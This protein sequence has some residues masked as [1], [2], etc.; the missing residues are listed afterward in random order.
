MRA[1]PP[2][3]GAVCCG[4]E[5]G[6]YLDLGRPF[7]VEKSPPNLIRSRYFQALFPGARFVFI[8]RHPIPVSLATEKWART[9]HLELMLHW[10]VAHLLMLRDIA[11]L[12]HAIVVRYEDMV[13]IFA[14]KLA[15]ISTFIGLDK[16]NSKESMSDQSE[17]Y[18]ARWERAHGV[19]MDVLQTLMGSEDGPMRRFGY[20]LTPPYA[21]PMLG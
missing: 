3:S 16:F 8:V 5:W 11:S 21:S 9:T 2:T 1:T 10:H 12:D 13:E 17:K 6:A 15:E 20:Q 19:D 14:D 7:I 4:R 18:F